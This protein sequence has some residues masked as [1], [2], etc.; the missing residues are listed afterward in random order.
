[1][2]LLRT[3]ADQYPLMLELKEAPECSLATAAELFDRLE[4]L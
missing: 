3:R 2:D 1:M 4:N